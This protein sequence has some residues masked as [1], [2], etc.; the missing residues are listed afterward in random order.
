MDVWMFILEKKT[1]AKKQVKRDISDSKKEFHQKKSQK[2]LNCRKKHN[3]RRF[4]F[5]LKCIIIKRCRSDH[6]N[7][8]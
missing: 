1:K 6:D 7:R 4:Q 3:T 2:V 5:L 8:S